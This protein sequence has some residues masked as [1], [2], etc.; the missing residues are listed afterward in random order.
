[1]RLIMVRHGEPDYAND[2]L[3]ATGLVQAEAAARRLMGEGIGEIYVSP[4]GRARQTAAA[5]EKALH[6]QATVL[7]YMHEITWSGE[8]DI[9][10]RGHPWFMADQM[11][12]EGMDI[13]DRA[14]KD[15]PYFRHNSAVDCY[16]RIAMGIDRLLALKGY[17]HDRLRYL[18][19][20]DR[21]ETIA[22]FSH[23]GSG[24]CA[25]AHMLGLP[26][27]YVATL[28]RYDFTSVTVLQ[29]P[30]KPGEYVFPRLE[31]NN[32]AGHI[33]TVGREAPVQE[34]A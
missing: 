31:L 10:F 19:T 13:L 29:F 28:M 8:E 23:G 32:D 9:P 1:M 4:M 15:H 16:D 26:F 11:A 24:S 5:A 30:L 12:A 33:R 17:H 2:C 6:L 21:D 27:P 20:A 7:D 34:K 18:C 22:L 25:L 14:W 3:T